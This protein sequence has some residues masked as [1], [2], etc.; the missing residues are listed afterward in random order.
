M[1]HCGNGS[2]LQVCRTGLGVQCYARLDQLQTDLALMRT[3][4]IPSIANDGESSD[5]DQMRLC[6]VTRMHRIVEADAIATFTCQ[7]PERE[8][9][10]GVSIDFVNQLGVQVLLHQCPQSVELEGRY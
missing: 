6:F 2:A 9:A 8:C 10:S 1:D 4:S 5:P 7:C 3:F